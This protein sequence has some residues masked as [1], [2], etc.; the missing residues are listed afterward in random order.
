MAT[1]P[2]IHNSCVFTHF[3]AQE[4]AVIETISKDWYVTNSGNPLT[5]NQNVSYKFILVKPTDN[6]QHAFNLERELVCVFSPFDDVHPR[7]LD[8]ISRAQSQFPPLR[9]DR[10]CSLV[11]SKDLNV[12]EK[13][14]NLLQNDTE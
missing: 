6:L 5:F 7:T 2:G 13:L 9:V 11:V 10:I 8:A 3:E 14:R 12:A 1:S 4:K